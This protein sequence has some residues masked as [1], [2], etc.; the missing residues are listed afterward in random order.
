VQPSASAAQTPST[1]Q[2][3]PREPLPPDEP[4]NFWDGDDPNLVN[5]IAHPFASKRYVRR[6]TRPIADRINE[7]EEITAE[8]SKTIKDV[9]SRAQQGIQLASE[10]VSLADQHATDAGNKAQM[11]Q[12][13]ATQASERVSTADQRV[14]NIDQYKGT[15][16][17]E[18][19]FRP[20]QF[21]L[22]KEAKDALD[23]M[24]APLKNQRDYMVEIQAF[25]SGNRQSAIAASQKMADSVLRYLILNHQIP[26]YRISTLS[27]GNAPIST[28]TTSN[29]PTSANAATARHIS[30]GRVE[31]NLLTND[32]LSSAQH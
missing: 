19:R 5:L 6:H 3:E 15:G 29:S 10:K 12:T 25:A 8:N 20:G 1:S 24:A 23:Q 14:G 13:A 26:V 27:M 32:S 30:G 4:A 9:D 2:I 18:I 21:T 17:T 7:L 11:A 22:S 28:A 31:V 16:Q